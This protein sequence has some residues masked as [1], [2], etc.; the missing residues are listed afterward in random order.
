MNDY[1]P[2][3]ALIHTPKNQEYTS[4]VEGLYSALDNGA[5]LEAVAV[6]CDHSFNLHVEMGAGISSL[7]SLQAKP[8][9]IPWSPAP[10]VSASS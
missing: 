3:G 2:E 6:M 1:K 7:V 4:S 9:I 5:I 8:N 10:V